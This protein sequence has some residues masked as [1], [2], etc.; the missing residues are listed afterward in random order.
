M[1]NIIL[2]MISKMS[3]RID[4]NDLLRQ[5]QDLLEDQA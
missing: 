5:V 1:K 3:I 2:K 4:I